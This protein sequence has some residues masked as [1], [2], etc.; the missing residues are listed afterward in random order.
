[1]KI[2]KKRKKVYAGLL[3][4]LVL[5]ATMFIGGCTNWQ[6]YV[7][8]EGDFLLEVSV[9]RTTVSIGDE[10]EITTTLI[11]NS[12][13]SL[14]VVFSNGNLAGRRRR[15]AGSL[16]SGLCITEN[17]GSIFIGGRFEGTTRRT[18]R[19]GASVSKTRTHIVEVID[20]NGQD[21]IVHFAGALAL[22]SIGTRD[23]NTILIFS[24]VVELEIV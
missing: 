17:M 23:S 22:F 11:N 18:L 4:L 13:R 2:I 16:R 14:P 1:M 20:C 24:N 15:L 9:D 5:T 21:K 8:Q 19:N 6:D 7:F 3:L 10:V 12:G